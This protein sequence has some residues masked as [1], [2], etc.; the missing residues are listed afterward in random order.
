METMSNH[1]SGWVRTEFLVPARGLIGFRTRFM[2]ETRGN[3]IASS[4]ADG[5]HP[6]MGPIDF[7][8]T[9]SLVADRTGAVTPFAMMNLQERGCFSVEPTSGVYQG[10]VVGESARHEDMAVNITKEKK[11]TNMRAA[12]SD[13]FEN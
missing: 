13:S 6:W 12:S 9:G 2:T 8:S 4:Y 5:H 1:G 11:P 7:R 3:G 10:Q